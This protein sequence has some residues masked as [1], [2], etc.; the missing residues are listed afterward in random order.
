L[1][2]LIYSLLGHVPVPGE[3]VELQD[4][5][6]FTVLTIDGR[7]IEQVRVERIAAPE[8]DGEDVQGEGQPRFSSQGSIFNFLILH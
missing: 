7:R 1:G 3:S 6:R 4:D 8:S 5:W 2:G